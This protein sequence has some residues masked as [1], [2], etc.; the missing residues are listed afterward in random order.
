MLADRDKV[1]A[2]IEQH[3]PDHVKKLQELVRQP[4]VSPENKGIRECAQLVLKYLRDLGCEASVVETK[5]NPVVYGRY[6]AGA[7]KTVLVYMM[8]D[9]MPTDEA[10]WKVDPFAGE[11][12]DQPPF[13]RC[14]VARGAVNTKGP[15]RAFLNACESIKATGQELPV[16]LILMAEGEEELGSRHLPEFVQKHEKE[17]AEADLVYFPDVGQFPEGNVIMELG[18]KGIVYFELE[19]NGKSWGKGPGEFGIH[20][21]LKAALDN[22]VWRM[23]QALASMTGPDGNKV[24]VKD[25]FRDVQV[26]KDDLMLVEKLGKTFTPDREQAIKDLFKVKNWVD[27]VSGVEMLKRLL[28]DPTLNIDGIWGGYTGEGT[29]TLLP[30]KVTVKMDVR[31][32][33]KMKNENVLPVIR[34]H[35]DSHGFPEI[36]IRPLEEGYDWARTSFHDPA[37]QATLKTYTEMG[38]E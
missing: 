14:L 38:V 15:M 20:G 12:V 5:G 24:L 25:L 23:V 13:K 2:Y 17:L 8:Y 31:L 10:G 37:V 21:S 34:K 11:L 3:F 22:P 7:P 33:P 19:L 35:L 28:L 16:N 1:F 4:S 32:V 29:K 36:R 26:S 27:G 30:H 9:T 6:D 18:V